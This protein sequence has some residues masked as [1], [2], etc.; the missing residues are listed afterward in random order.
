M[1]I[2]GQEDKE[3]ENKFVGGRNRWT[4]DSFINWVGAGTRGD[5]AC[6]QLGVTVVRSC[7]AS[8]CQTWR[9]CVQPRP[10]TGLL[11]RL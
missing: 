4:Y 11:Q 3:T 6:S 7:S 2:A 9:S 1:V 10:S 8:A 5:N